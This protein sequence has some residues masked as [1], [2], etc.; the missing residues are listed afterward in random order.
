[1]IAQRLRVRVRVAIDRKERV[2]ARAFRLTRACAR[3]P[4]PRCP[5]WTRTSQFG[6]TSGR[7]ARRA[8]AGNRS[9]RWRWRRW[10]AD[11][12]WCFSAGSRRPEQCRRYPRHPAFPS[13]PET[14]ARKRRAIRHSAAAPRRKSCRKPATICRTR[15]TGNDGQLV[16]G[17][18]K[19]NIFQVVDPRTAD[20]DEILH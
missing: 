4:G 9:T 10:S 3:P 15:D 11:C 6:Q 1:M 19:R 17:N 7:R 18:R 12:A 5:C 2:P 20:P 8:G 14:G 13:A 16:M